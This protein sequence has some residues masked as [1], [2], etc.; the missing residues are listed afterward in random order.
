MV[1]SPQFRALAK[2]TTL[3][4]GAW[5]VVGGVLGAVRG[6]AL[7]GQSVAS[8]TLNFAVMYAVVGAIAG[9]VTSLVVARAERGR[10]VRDLS[11]GRFA[12]WG[13]LGGLAPPALLGALGLLAG[14]PLIAVLP[15]A[16]LGVVGG[17]I[18][19]VASASAVTAVKRNALREPDS[20]PE[21]PAT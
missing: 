8:A 12:V 3:F 11:A 17:A 15:L 2:L 10:S 18:G 21:L 14:A 20:P 1:F 13:V 16:G 9:I 4:A 6:A 7:T 19:G 5:A